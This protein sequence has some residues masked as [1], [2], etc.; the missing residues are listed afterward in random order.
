M[1][2]TL[3]LAL[4]L[5]LALAAVPGAAQA[6]TT[7][8]IGLSNTDLKHPELIG[9]LGF[10]MSSSVNV[11]GKMSPDSWQVGAGWREYMGDNHSGVFVGPFILYVNKDGSTDADMGAEIGYRYLQGRFVLEGLG[12]IAVTDQEQSLNVFAGV[13]F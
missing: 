2:K 8:V 13:R 3:T 11:R 12:R 10:G 1:K 4:I 7:L 9:E 5:A 6:S